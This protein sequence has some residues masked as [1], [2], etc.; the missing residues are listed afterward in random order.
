MTKR[1]I[2]PGRSVSWALSLLGTQS[3]GHSVSWALGLLGTQSTGHSVHL[4]TQSLGARSL[5]AQSLGARSLGTRST[6]HWVATPEKTCHSLMWMVL[7]IYFTNKIIAQTL[8]RF[9]C[10]K[11]VRSSNFMLHNLFLTWFKWY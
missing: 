7:L 9:I 1:Q 2:N 10:V 5:G 3:P 8:F 4:G 11:M 6:G